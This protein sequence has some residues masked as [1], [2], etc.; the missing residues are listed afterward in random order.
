MT[1]TLL[2]LAATTLLA[3][4][5]KAATGFGPALV[6]VSLGSLLVGPAQAVVLAAFLDLASGASLLWIDRRRLRPGHWWRLALTMSAGA[7]AGG[8]LL[9]VI[10]TETLTR[11]VAL[12]ILGFG[13]WMLLQRPD[14][15][16]GPTARAAPR[17]P[18]VEHG[19]VA[20]GGVSGGLIGVGGP[21]LVVYYGARLPKQAFRAT[22]VS[23]LLAAAVTRVATYTATGLVDRDL[24]VLVAASLPA[25]PLGV[26]LGN[27]V[28]HRWSERAFRTAIA[29]LVTA[30]GVRLL[31]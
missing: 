29:L 27:R 4:A 24:L 19:I 30:A 25:L 15:T 17:R 8:L 14:H 31:V 18:L 16:R 13:L 12:G 26:A 6:V 23:L 22:I 3:F 1:A 20:A 10:P 21:P 11:I 7:V 5:V 2:A 28:F 9:D